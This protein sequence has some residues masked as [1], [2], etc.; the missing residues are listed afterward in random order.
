MIAALMHSPRVRRAGTSRVLG[1]VES[2]TG[3]GDRVT[4]LVASLPQGDS[5]AI[6]PTQAAPVREDEAEAAP[7]Q[8]GHSE[9]LRTI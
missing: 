1:T 5:A 7:E 6:A 9:P 8:V 2:G 3:D 4:S